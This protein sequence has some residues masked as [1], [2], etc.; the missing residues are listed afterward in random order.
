MSPDDLEGHYRRLFADDICIEQLEAEIKQLTAN[1]AAVNAETVAQL[2][3]HER[4]DE[5]NIRLVAEVAKLTAQVAYSEKLGEMVLHAEELRHLI[6]IGKWNESVSVLGYKAEV[7]R[8][9]TMYDATHSLKL[10]FEQ[11]THHLARENARLMK[12]VTKMAEW[13]SNKGNNEDG[14]SAEQ[15]IKHAVTVVKAEG[16]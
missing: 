14:F 4:M 9:T 15:Y 1:L 11:Q 3:C 13:L 16:K 2:A 10:N 8:L 6:T 7:A 12:V 5:E